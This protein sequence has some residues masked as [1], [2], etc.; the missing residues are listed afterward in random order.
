MYEYSDKQYPT[1]LDEAEATDRIHSI[2]TANDEYKLSIVE[3]EDGKQKTELV[4]KD[5]SKFVYSVDVQTNGSSTVYTKTLQ[6]KG[7]KFVKY[8]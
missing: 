8:F 2:R 4:G 5:K 7:L 3:F 6:S 1:G